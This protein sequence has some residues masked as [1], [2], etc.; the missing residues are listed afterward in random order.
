MD[1]KELYNVYFD[2][3]HNVTVRKSELAQIQSFNDVSGQSFIVD[4]KTLQPQRIDVDIID[5]NVSF[6]LDGILFTCDI[7][8]HTDR[9]IK[10]LGM[11]QESVQ[12]IDKIVAPMPGLV[13]EIH[14][15]PNDH[16]LAGDP[17]L[18][19]QA[20]KMENVIRAPID[21]EIEQIM[22]TKGENVTKDTVLMIC[23]SPTQ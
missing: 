23:K 7:E 3:S 6:W 4:G 17:L 8:D 19:L 20:M 15:A 21:L 16:L 22:V 12:Q 5:K 14:A 1:S 13:I 11:D 18:V 10:K 2:G 9:L